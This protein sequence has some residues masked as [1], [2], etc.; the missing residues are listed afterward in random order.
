[1]LTSGFLAT[2]HC[3]GTITNGSLQVKSKPLPYL[4]C[5]VMCVWCAVCTV[6]PVCV[7]FMCRKM[8]NK[9]AFTFD[10][11]RNKKNVPSTLHFSEVYYGPITGG[12]VFFFFFKKDFRRSTPVP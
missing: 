7:F 9:T 2:D 4:Q 3:Y 12:G 8:S 11:L 10:I 6:C 1:V 5:N